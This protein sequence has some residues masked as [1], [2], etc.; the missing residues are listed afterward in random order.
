DDEVS[1]YLLKGL[2]ADTRYAVVEATRGADGLRQAREVR[3]AVIVL[4]LVM[5]ETSGFEVLERLKADPAT[6]DIP[7][8]VSTAKVLAEEERRRLA[9]HAVAILPKET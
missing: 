3:P 7:V 8:I 6:R 9:A 4:D 1:R 5:P 2:L